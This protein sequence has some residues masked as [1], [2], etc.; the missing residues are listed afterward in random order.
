MFSSI[1]YGL[2]NEGEWFDKLKGGVSKENIQAVP[3]AGPKGATAYTPA[4]VK[5]WGVPKGAVN[6][7]GAAYFLRYYLDVSSFDQSKTFHNTQFEEVFKIVASPSAKKKVMYGSGVVDYIVAG[8]YQNICTALTNAGAQNVT[9]ELA[10][11][12]GTIQTAI[13]RANKAIEEA[14]KQ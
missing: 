9:T 11:K 2:Y 12:S 14:N 1:S 10:S 4:R 7:D 5:T 3:M 13:K 6:P 8:N